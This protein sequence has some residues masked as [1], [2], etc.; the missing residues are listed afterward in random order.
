MKSLQ[1]KTKFLEFGPFGAP[2]PPK[3]GPKSEFLFAWGFSYIKRN[4]LCKYE[5]STTKNT[6][7][8][9]WT[10]WGPGAAQKGP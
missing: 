6:I 2:G 9:I 5:V 4:I 7:F 8:G 1:P 10:I 3:R